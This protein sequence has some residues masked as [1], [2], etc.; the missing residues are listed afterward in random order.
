MSSGKFEGEHSYTGCT[1]TVR[2]SR[3][4]GAH[5]LFLNRLRVWDVTGT[6]LVAMRVWSDKPFEPGMLMQ[7]QPIAAPKSR[8]STSMALAALEEAIEPAKEVPDA[9]KD[10]P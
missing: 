9:A 3:M 1:V 4:G 6:P 5:A 7:M 8:I 10:A 2:S